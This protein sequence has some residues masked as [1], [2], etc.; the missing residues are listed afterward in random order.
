MKRVMTTVGMVLFAVLIMTGCGAGSNE[1]EK[2]ARKVAEK[3]C[4]MRLMALS[5]EEGDFDGLTQFTQKMA[6]FSELVQEIDNKYDFDADDEEFEEL[7]REQ[8][9]KTPCGD[10]ELDDLFDFF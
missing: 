8:L 2:D 9:K 1:M 5:I 3:A 10:I 6:E 4:E 7:I